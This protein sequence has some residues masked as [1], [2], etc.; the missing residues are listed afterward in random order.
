MPIR[1]KS[2]YRK[3]EFE[4]V[5]PDGDKSDITIVEH[6]DRRYIQFESN[7]DTVIMDGPMLLD[8]ADTYR[9]IMHSKMRQAS[10][11]NRGK[12]Q[13]KAPK[14]VDHRSARAKEIEDSVDESMKNYDDEMP[15]IQTLSPDQQHS[16]KVGNVDYA[17]MQSGVDHDVLED[18]DE[19]P[20]DWSVSSKDQSELSGWKKDAVERSN[21]RRPDLR[22]RGSAGK[23][24][25]RIGASELI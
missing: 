20:E 14:V 7:G 12:P 4:Y 16:R 25:K 18:V 24:F 15:P 23:G 19:T 22:S 1:E 11:P 13:L 17:K 8:M 5:S 9:E 3:Y 6:G 2:T 21:I 10:K